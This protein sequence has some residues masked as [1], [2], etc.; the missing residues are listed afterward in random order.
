MIW[1]S[2][3]DYK[4]IFLI[5]QSI[6]YLIHHSMKVTVGRYIYKSHTALLALSFEWPTY[7]LIAQPPLER[8]VNG[9][10]HTCI[11]LFLFKHVEY[12]QIPLKTVEDFSL[13]K[14]T[15]HHFETFHVPWISVNLSCVPGKWIFETWKRHKNPITFCKIA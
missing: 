4:L 6:K 13:V 15:V 11:I 7:K 2:P 1:N 12:K 10:I 9:K 5:I 3:I 14:Y 8:Q